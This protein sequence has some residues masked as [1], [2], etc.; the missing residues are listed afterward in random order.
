MEISAITFF[1]RHTRITI[2]FH[3]SLYSSQVDQLRAHLLDMLP[4]LREHLCYNRSGLPFTEEL[5]DTELGHVF[6]HVM[7]AILERRG[8][9]ASGQTTWN[10]RRD[11]IGTYHVTIATGKK[12][13]VKE[14]VLVAQAILTNLLLGPVL[15]IRLPE[16]RRVRRHEPLPVYRLAKSRDKTAPQL[17]FA[18]RPAR[19]EGPETLGAS[20]R[21]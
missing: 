11:P 19:H 1:P 14:S 5:E 3:H 2:R 4:S 13:L 9:C 8:L 21:G 7:L 17:L 12:H 15:P 18:S 6:E 10:W 16:G 20:T